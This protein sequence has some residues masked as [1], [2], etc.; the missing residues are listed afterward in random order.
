MANFCAVA[1]VE[2]FLQLTITGD[3]TKVAACER[4]IDEATAAIRNYTHQYIE[5]VEDDSYTFDVWAPIYNL[6]LPEMPV[7]SVASV[8]EDGTLLEASDTDGYVLANYGQL[9]RRGARWAKGPQKVVV[10][11]THGY[12][13]IPADVVAV[14]V[15]AAA[16]GYQ[17][18]LKATEDVGVPGVQSKAIGDYSVTYA[19]GGET[20]LGASA[21]RMLLMSEK[22]I[23]DK[24]RYVGP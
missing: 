4:A 6:V 18:G 17:A 21:A 12:A 11:Y 10:V 24:Y 1:A 14:C 15:R 8:T 3:A 20:A 2:K 23:L 7:I 19:T 13:T 22:D 5:K 16:R 9:I